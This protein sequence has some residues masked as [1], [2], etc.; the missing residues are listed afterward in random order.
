MVGGAAARVEKVVAGAVAVRGEDFQAAASVDAAQ[1]EETVSA[2]AVA[3]V[4]QR[5]EEDEIP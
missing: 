4:R 2:S 3:F 5:E 1:R